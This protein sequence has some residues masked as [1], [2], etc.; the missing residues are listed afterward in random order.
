MR[1]LRAA[2]FLALAMALSAPTIALAAHSSSKRPPGVPDCAH[3]SLAALEAPL[4][5]GGAGLEYEGKSPVG[6]TCTYKALV[7]G[8]YSDLLQVSL[9]ATSYGVFLKAE[10]RA[11]R[12]Y[13]G[14]TPG[15]V[16][17]ILR[18]RVAT[19]FETIHV[20]NGLAL[21]PCPAGQALP[22]LGPPLCHGEPDWATVNVYAYAK[23]KPR[24]PKAFITVA[25]AGQ[26]GVVF[27]GR[28]MPIVNGILS[29]RIH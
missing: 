26:S 15:G 5:V 17:V 13:S 22:E 21:Q 16:F 6:N 14:P 19:E 12:A 1:T 24:G 20:V 27:L 9:Q 25:L 7:P 28:V 10:Q 11:R 2:W 18:S 8:H 23:L 3:F 29:G 4:H